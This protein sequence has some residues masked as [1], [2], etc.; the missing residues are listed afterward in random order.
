MRI[1]FL[2]NHE[3]SHQV[4]HILPIALAMASS[5]ASVDIQVFTSGGPADEEV[6]RQVA[7]SGMPVS[8]T[9]LQDAGPIG[10]T[11]SALS[12][13][14]IPGRRISILKINRDLFAD[15]DA[16]VVPEKT[17][18]MLK[19]KFGLT[20]VPL[21]HTRH[22][23]GDRAIGF[24]KASGIFDLVLLSGEK[25]RD[26]LAEAGLL[27]EDGYAIVG[28]PKFDRLAAT[29]PPQRIFDNAR[30]IVL[31]NPHS[32]P[33]LSSWYSMGP[34]VLDYFASQDAFNLLFAPHVMLFNK[35]YHLTLS[36]LRFSAVPQ[37][38]V[39]LR[40]LRQ[41][42]IDL[43]SEASVD[44][45]YTRMA[46]I[47]IGDASSQVYEFIARP[48]PCIFLNPGKLRWKND[49]NFTHWNAGAVVS[50]MQELREALQR[51]VNQPDEYRDVQE[52]LF[53]YTFDLT[54]EPSAVRAA[55]AIIEWLRR[56]P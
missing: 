40:N 12:G 4:G 52:K 41:M 31:Y 14:A 2:I 25:I 11:V 39:G 47:Y 10:K 33:A 27:K 21:I 37:V 49:P 18:L 48:R 29:A 8:I 53:H 6:R 9:R 16:L 34:A 19:T 23:A 20:G 43:G 51:A 54:P 24:D 45:T 44:M 50:N 55:R 15:L 26:R 13:G 32:S 28:Y 3:G 7:A 36:P 42:R 35:R 30:P 1:G 56:N 38:R 46:D 22:G 5:G 17:S